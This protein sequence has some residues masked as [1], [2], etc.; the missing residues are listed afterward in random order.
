MKLESG[1]LL[2]DLQQVIKDLQR[3]IDEQLSRNGALEQVLGARDQELRDLR[4]LVKA[5]DDEI[6]KL[7]AKPVRVEISENTY[8]KQLLAMQN[9][10]I[11]AQERLI[12]LEGQDYDY[13]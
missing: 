4:A 10:L 3:T 9:K 13:R 7:K 8:L 2:P 12:T 11:M 5:R 1:D 6:A